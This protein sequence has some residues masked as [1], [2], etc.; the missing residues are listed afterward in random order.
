MS[1]EDEDMGSMAWPG[2]VDILSSVII[3]FVFF[4]MVVASALYFHIIIFK[5]KILAE[6]AESTSA[7]SQM[8]ELATTNRALTKK[9]KE[10][11]EEMKI[12]EEINEDNEIQLFKEDSGFAESK[13]QDIEVNATEDSI[14]IIFGTDSISVTQDSQDKIN[15]MM[16]GFISKY[17]G[18][19]VKV[20]ISSNKN[21]ASI[22]DI[23]ARRLAVARMLNVRNSFLETDIPTEQV[24]A[25]VVEK[26]AVNNS[27]NWVTI[28]FG[29]K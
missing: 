12:L 1:D 4:V 26:D 8:Q 25:N 24:N 15:E 7:S 27:H 29:R 17:S 23:T 28:K 20:S 16:D 18:K 5:S 21:P 3:M 11:T 19:N 6:I 10:M 22:N 2:F 13:E 9:I 14:T